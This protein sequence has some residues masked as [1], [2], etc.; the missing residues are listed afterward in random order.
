[1]TPAAEQS[2]FFN[3]AFYLQAGLPSMDDCLHKAESL[4]QQGDPASIRKCVSYFLLSPNPERGLKLGLTFVK[5]IL[6]SQDWRASDVE[7]LLSLLGCIRSDRLQHHKS[8]V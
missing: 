5:G 7:Q 3:F 2:C 8:T 1:M 4:E 6:S